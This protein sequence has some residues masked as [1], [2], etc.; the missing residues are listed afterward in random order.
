MSSKRKKGKK[1]PKLKPYE[2]QKDV[3]S[4]EKYVD[5]ILE[6]ITVE[7]VVLFELDFEVSPGGDGD[8]EDLFIE[9]VLDDEEE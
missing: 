9:F 1:E 5:Y 7:D 2:I 8:N 6:A 3:I 4:L